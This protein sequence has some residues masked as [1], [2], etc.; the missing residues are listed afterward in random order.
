[1]INNLINYR[2][3]KLLVLER[4]GSDKH[5]MALWKCRCDCG[6]EKII[7]GNSLSQGKS[8]S[9]GCMQNKLKDLVG[10]K[11]NRLTIVERAENNKNGQAMWVC[12]CE[13]GNYITAFASNIVRGITKSCGCYSVEVKKSRCIDITDKR[14]GR[15]LVIRRIEKNDSIRTHWECICDCGNITVVAVESLKRGLTNSCG[16][17][18]DERM[19]KPVGE[20]STHKLFVQYKRDAKRRGYEFSLT[21][22]EFIEMI[23]NNCYYCGESPNRETNNKGVNG[24]I[25]YNGIDRV[26][27]TVGYV[28]DNVV[29]C[30]MD[31]NYSK[32]D[33]SVTDFKNWIMRVAEHQHITNW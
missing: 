5:R 32:L 12:K 7:N 17:I 19:K 15:L 3:G 31:C 10:M 24:N 11:F 16:C 1:M 14:F 26:D 8:N 4:A 22:E 6:V 20:S 30:C 2:F 33:R 28:K 29:T 21:N 9:C 23:F 18:W 27:N 25:A 13:C